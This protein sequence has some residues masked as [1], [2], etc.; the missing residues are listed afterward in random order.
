MAETSLSPSKK[1]GYE[2][3]TNEEGYLTHYRA[4]WV[5]YGNRRRPG[6]YFEES[7]APMA[8]ER[9]F[10]LLFALIAEKS[11]EA[12]QFDVITAYLNVS[13]DDREI[14]MTLPTKRRH[15]L[16][17]RTSSVWLMTSSTSMVAQVQ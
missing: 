11:W 8:A 10:K 14:Y 16:L 12:R 6:I 15:S 4:R 3:K 17:P 1:V 13:I 7:Y 2:A 5:I 9:S